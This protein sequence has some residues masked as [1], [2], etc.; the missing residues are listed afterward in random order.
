M[1]K[2]KL[3]MKPTPHYLSSTAASKAMRRPK[4]PMATNTVN[5]RHGGPNMVPSTQTMK[6]PSAQNPRLAATQIARPLV[7]N[8]MSSQN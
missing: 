1:K 7:R 6:K 2:T 4:S 8:L 5:A 3:R